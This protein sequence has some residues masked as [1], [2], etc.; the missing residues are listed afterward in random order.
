MSLLIYQ[1]FWHFFPSVR[2]Q[3]PW[4]WTRHGVDSG[5]TVTLPSLPWYSSLKPGRF[6]EW[7]L[8][9]YTMVSCDVES[10]EPGTSLPL[11]LPIMRLVSE[12]PLRISKKSWLGSVEKFKN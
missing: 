2:M 5:V 7:S 4:L 10:R 3:R 11:N 9:K 8:W 1:P 6:W 12:G